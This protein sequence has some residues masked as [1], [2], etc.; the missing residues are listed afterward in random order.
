MISR[1]GCCLLVLWAAVHTVAASETLPAQTASRVDDAAAE[2]LASTG[3]PS[4]SIAIVEGGTLVYTHAYGLAHVGPDASARVDARYAIDSVSKE[5]TAAAILLLAEDGKLLLDDPLSRW[6][7]ALGGAS[8][9][10]LRQILNHTSGIRDYWP[11]DFVTPAMTHPITT[12]ALIDTWAARPLDFPP[13]TDWQY[14]NTGYVL[15]GAVVEQV[16]GEP[17]FEFLRRRIFL[18]LHMNAV[19]DYG[20]AERPNEAAGYTRFGLGPLHPAPRE[21]AGW[22]FG[23]AGLAMRPSDLALWDI[24]LI[25]RS[26]LGAKSYDA[27]RQ[28]ATLSGGR[29]TSYGLGLHVEH[30]VDGRL[31]LS[32]SG[33]GSGFLAENRIWPDD[34]IAIVVLTNND[35][36]PPEYLADRLAYLILPP[37]AAELRARTLFEA[38]QNGTVDTSL[39]TAA[40][41]FYLTDQALAELHA[42][43]SALGPARLIE[44]ESE[45]RRGGLE[46]RVWKILCRG[47]RLRAVERTAPN[48]QLTEFMIT[49]R[50]D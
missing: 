47:G 43:L 5:F 10:T 15:A 33:G 6:F 35:W 36:A 50:E 39:F 31:R 2:W 34:K 49:R 37:T 48:G 14:S 42:G 20:S 32:H 25:D 28:P 29:Q 9:V 13:G 7:P 8:E 16:S 22:L 46:T 11:E 26:L 3:A 1:Q 18:P 30:D 27:E 23:A 12:Q 41:R 19:E 4:V 24:S 17:L 44:L 38:F 21:A 45:T 40:G